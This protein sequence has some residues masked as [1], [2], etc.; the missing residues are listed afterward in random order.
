VEDKNYGEYHHTD[1]VGKSHRKDKTEQK[2]RELY[3]R[4]LAA[5]RDN[6]V[7]ALPGKYFVCTT[8]GNTYDNE[9]AARCGICMTPK[10]R[11]VAYQ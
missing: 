1:A 7:S 6:K 10:E 9:A 4:A 3:S 8:C 5:L 11:F 2:H